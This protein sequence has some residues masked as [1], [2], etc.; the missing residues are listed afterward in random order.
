MVAPVAFL[1]LMSSDTDRLSI[2]SQARVEGLP[3]F[4][5]NQLLQSGN[6][7]PR[8]DGS[9]RHLMQ[10]RDYALNTV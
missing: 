1:L 3:S 2:T 5:L 8:P 6:L 4:M 10:R 7:F 9:G